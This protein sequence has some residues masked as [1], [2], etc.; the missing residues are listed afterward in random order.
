MS[1]SAPKVPAS[2]RLRQEASG[3]W[4]ATRRKPS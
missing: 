2:F 1:R 4:K 3:E